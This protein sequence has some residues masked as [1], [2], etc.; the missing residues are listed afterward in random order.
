[1]AILSAGVVLSINS[2]LIIGDEAEA[3]CTVDNVVPD[4]ITLHKDGEPMRNVTNH[5]QLRTSI[6]VNEDLHGSQISCKAQL[7]GGILISSDPVEVSVRGNS[8]IN[9]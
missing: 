3:F 1:M 6:R 5:T 9:Q 8:I 2:S 4:S 7:K